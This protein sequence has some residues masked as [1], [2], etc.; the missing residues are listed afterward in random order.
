MT[1]PPG[2][3][4]RGQEA[5]FCG[6]RDSSGT[7]LNGGSRPSLTWQLTYTARSSDRAARQVIEF[8]WG[9][10]LC[11]AM[12]FASSY[13]LNTNLCNLTASGELTDLLSIADRF[14]C[15]LLTLL[16]EIV[17]REHRL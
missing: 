10:G 14:K 2:T 7:S 15:G 17:T 13:S 5:I 12:T 3:G 6:P 8:S 9:L 4:R 16:D 1:L 11:P